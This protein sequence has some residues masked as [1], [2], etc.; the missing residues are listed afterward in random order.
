MY[1]WKLVGPARIV[2]W[3]LNVFIKSGHLLLFIRSESLNMS[4]H[5]IEIGCAKE[6]AAVKHWMEQNFTH[7]ETSQSKISFSS[8][9]LCAS[10]SERNTETVEP[11]V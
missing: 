6:N 7:I 9:C 4:A 8:R 5:C 1:T 11:G 3:S 10:A 2:S